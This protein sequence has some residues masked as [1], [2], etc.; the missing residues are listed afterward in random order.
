MSMKLPITIAA[1]LVAAV[2]S[3]TAAN[4]AAMQFVKSQDA[5]INSCQDMRGQIDRTCLGSSCRAFDVAYVKRTVGPTVPVVC[6]QT[7]VIG[8][9][10]QVRSP[11]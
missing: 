3:L 10:L 11:S 2:A 6:E 4:A 9:V 7:A 5:R 1:A 8:G